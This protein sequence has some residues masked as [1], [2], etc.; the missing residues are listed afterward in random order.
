MTIAA[1]IQG[2]DLGTR[3]VLFELD[4]TVF[5]LGII[6]LAPGTIGSTSVGFGGETYAPHPLRA[7]GFD[8]I[9][10][11]PL[12]RPTFEVANLDNSFTALVEQNDDLQGGI[13]RRIRT[14]GRY[15]DDGAE[16]DG[17]VHLPLDVYQLSQKT[18][19]TQEVIGWTCSALMDQEGV[20][21][22]ARQI[23]RD[24]CDHPYRRWD[25]V[26]G[27]FDYTHVTCP[28]TGTSYFDEDDNVVGASLDSCSKRLTGCRLRFGAN[29]VLPTRAFPG[30]ARLKAR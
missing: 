30:V 5:D 16:P 14:Y 20:L 2:A 12:P 23:I 6:R 8:L 17:D 11:G 27:A 1:H 26:T 10:N 3:V 29:G 15:L 21:L 4:L 18:R 24:Y 13:L 9:S 7:E 25:A 19:H 22:P 28:Y